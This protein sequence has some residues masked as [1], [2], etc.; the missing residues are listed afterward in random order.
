MRDVTGKVAFVTGGASGIGLGIAQVFLDAG[1]K[2]V[3]A[4]IR[5]NALFAACAQ[6]GGGNHLLAL[7]LD[8][9]NRDQWKSALAEASTA[10]G[11]VH[12]L[13][14]NAGVGMLGD[15]RSVTYDDWDWGLSV[16]LGGAVNGVQTFL[17][18]FLAH[19]EPSHIVNTSTVGATLAGPGAIVYLSAKAAVLTLTECLKC[20]LQDTNVSVTALLPGPTATNIHE[21][22]K[23]RPAR[24]GKTGLKEIEERLAKG[25]LFSNGMDP[26]DVGRMVLDGIQR[27][28]LFVYTHNDFREGVGQRCRALL[29]SFPPGPVDPERAKAFGFPVTNAHYAAIAAAAEALKRGEI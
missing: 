23:L 9:A 18:H 4:D 10:F 14:N 24:F 3:I 16:N 6:L 11:H 19:G 27:D 25:P 8:V 21:V 15:A 22:G 12:V 29:A 7:P 5:D 28:R 20:D 13:C 1:M 2:V 17:P 26:I